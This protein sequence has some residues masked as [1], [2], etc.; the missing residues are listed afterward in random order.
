M[1]EYIEVPDE[2]LRDTQGLKR[3]FDLSYAFARSLEP[4]PTRRGK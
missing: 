4:K 1:N 2:L 3:C